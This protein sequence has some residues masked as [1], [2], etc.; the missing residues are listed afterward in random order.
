LNARSPIWER[1]L[2]RELRGIITRR[3]SDT[4]AECRIVEAFS[5]P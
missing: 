1:A 2:R 4:V 3:A 5:P